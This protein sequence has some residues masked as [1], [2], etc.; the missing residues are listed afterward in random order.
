M[1]LDFLKKFMG[2][3]DGAVT[4]DW[5]VLSAA[6]VGLAVAGMNATNSGVMTL[7]G[8]ISSGVANQSVGTTP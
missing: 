8:A 1:K 4:V 7:A 3:D 6:I 5:V 2:G